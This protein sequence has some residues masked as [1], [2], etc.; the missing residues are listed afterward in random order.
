MAQL[1]L[2]VPRE[3]YLAHLLPEDARDIRGLSYALASGL[4]L[5]GMPSL[6]VAVG[7]SARLKRDENVAPVYND[8]DIRALPKEPRY[9]IDLQEHVIRIL[10][11]YPLMQRYNGID[12]AYGWYDLITQLQTGRKVDI[13]FL[14]DTNNTGAAE[15]LQEHDKLCLPYSI[16]TD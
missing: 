15:I 13:I 12:L 7:S 14:H 8:I 1:S 5:C 2:S 4:Y 3:Q 11:G 16:L 10:G 6:V 9:K